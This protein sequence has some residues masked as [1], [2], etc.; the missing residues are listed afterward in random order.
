MMR[1][2]L[3]HPKDWQSTMDTTE[4]VYRIPCENCD[5]VYVGESGRKFGTRLS[6]TRRSEECVW[7]SRISQ[8]VRNCRDLA[9]ESCYWLGSSRHCGQGVRYEDKMDKKEAIHIRT[10]GRK[11]LNQEKGFHRPSHVYDRPLTAPPPRR[12]KLKF[13][14]YK[15]NSHFRWRPPLGSGNVNKVKFL[16]VKYVIFVCYEFT[17]L[18]TVIKLSGEYLW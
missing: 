6:C 5:K 4:S 12:S 11:A 9:R 13:K 14:K 3:V 10:E 2:F 18:P 17:W 7:K 16:I 15:D 1:Q 8:E